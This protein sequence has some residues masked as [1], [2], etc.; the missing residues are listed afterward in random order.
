MPNVG[1]AGVGGRGHGVALGLVF[2]GAELAD[3]ERLATFSDA[4]LHEENRAFRVEFD[5]HGDDQQRQKQH[6]KPN[7]CHD[8]VEAPLEAESYFVFIFRHAA[9]PPYLERP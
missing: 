8:T 4:M 3:S 7:E 1:D 9:W 5:E 6:D 2:H